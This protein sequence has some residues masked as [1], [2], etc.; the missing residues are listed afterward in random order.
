MSIW[1]RPRAL[2]SSHIPVFPCNPP[3]NPVGSTISVYPKSDSS[4]PSLP[5]HTGPSHHYLSSRASCLLRSSHFSCLRPFNAYIRVCDSS[6]LPFLPRTLRFLMLPF[7]PG[8]H[9]GCLVNTLEPL[10][11]LF[12]QAGI[13]FPQKPP[14]LYPFLDSD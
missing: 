10:L 13:L 3:A 9:A 5:Q 11:L 2:K 8:Q 4:F 12:P 1:V 6:D 7:L 14:S